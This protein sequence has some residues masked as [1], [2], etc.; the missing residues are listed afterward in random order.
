MLTELFL[1][2]QAAGPSQKRPAL[3]SRPAAVPYRERIENTLDAGGEVIIDFSGV[4]ATQ[5]FV[6]ELIG[7]VV[8]RRG[9]TSLSQISFRGCSTDLKAIIRFVVS[10]R[11]L[12]RASELHPVGAHH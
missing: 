4:E 6:D 5:S 11:A 9:A 1:H 3:G 7:V 2:P 10:D 12:Q 8:M